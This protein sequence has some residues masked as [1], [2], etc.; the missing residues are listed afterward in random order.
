[1]NKKILIIGIVGLFLGS[2]VAPSINAGI[3]KIYSTKDY[4]DSATRY[5]GGYDTD[6]YERSFYLENLL[7]SGAEAADTD[8]DMEIILHKGIGVYGFTVKNTG[9]VTLNIMRFEISAQALIGISDEV[10][11]ELPFPIP[12]KPGESIRFSRVMW[13]FG[14]GEFGASVTTDKISGGI[15]TLAFFLGYLVWIFR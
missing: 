6:N 14:P 15:A 5:S 8:L 11:E 12:I 3:N 7:I 2:V 13:A 10:S 9:T 1:M 4:K